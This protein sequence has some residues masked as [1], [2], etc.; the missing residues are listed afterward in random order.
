[1]PGTS[2]SRED[3][4][5]SP[6]QEPLNQNGA[7]HLAGRRSSK[8]VSYLLHVKKS[9]QPASKQLRALLR[10][11]TK[12]ILS[13]VKRYF[14]QILPGITTGPANAERSTSEE[15]SILEKFGKVKHT[16]AWTE[17][18]AQLP[19]STPTCKTPKPQILDFASR[20][21]N[22][23]QHRKKIKG[24]AVPCSPTPA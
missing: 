13:R 8:V 10:N 21:E 23:D 3:S 9:E 2:P 4:L 17:R 20:Q 6:T 12:R 14:V 19:A 5:P 22:K 15:E 16:T 7:D 11:A 18:G 24:A 1:M